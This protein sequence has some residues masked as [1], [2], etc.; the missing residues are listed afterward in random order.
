MAISWIKSRVQYIVGHYCIYYNLQ[1]VITD[2]IFFCNFGKGK[3]SW[4][5]LIGK[6]MYG[7]ILNLGFFKYNN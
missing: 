4:T 3:T 1:F 5:S 7:V 2:F 6:K